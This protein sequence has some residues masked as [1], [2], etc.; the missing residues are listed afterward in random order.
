M[1]ARIIVV[2]AVAAGLGAIG[3]WALESDAP[4]L[5]VSV[6]TQ[7]AASPPASGPS[8]AAAR[9]A[10]AAGDC[11]DLDADGCIDSG[12]DPARDGLAF[13]NE[14]ATGTLSAAALIAL[15]GAESVCATVSGQGCVLYPAAAQ[16]ARQVNEAMVGGRCEG[17]AVL[18][19][20][21][22]GG[23]ISVEDLDPE[24]GT[25]SA[26]TRA[27]PA[28][29]GAIQTWWATQLL[30]PAQAAA[31]SSRLYSPSSIVQ[32]L[33]GGLLSDAGYTLGLEVPGGA[34]SVLPFAVHRS[35]EDFAV[36]VYDSDYPGTVQ[37]VLVDPR[38]ERWTYAPG[39][40]AVS[41]DAWEGGM[42][43]IE[44]TPMSI[45]ALPARAP[46]DASMLAL[47][48]VAGATAG[49]VTLLVTSPDPSA[50]VGVALTVKGRTIDASELG[51]RLPRGVSVRRIL[52]TGLAGSGVT[53]TINRG[54]VPSFAAA[55][56]AWDAAGSQTPTTI[57][58][59]AP[60]RPRITV[61]SP[62][63]LTADALP[64]ANLVR[65]RS[66]ARDG[67]PLVVVES[68]RTFVR[69]PQVNIA[70]GLNSV[71]LTL[72]SGAL[73]LEVTKGKAGSAQLAFRSRGGRV[74]ADYV[75]PFDTPSGR[76]RVANVSISPSGR[77]VDEAEAFARPVPIDESV[78]E[79][80]EAVSSVDA[81][82]AAGSADPAAAS[83][84][85]AAQLAI[86]VSNVGRSGV[87]GT[88][89]RLTSSGG[90][91]TG[92]VRFVVTGEDCAIVRG[93]LVTTAPTT[94]RVTATRAGSG[95]FGASASSPVAFTFRA[96]RQAPLVIS[97]PSRPGAAAN[98][99]RLTAGGGS[100]S[101]ALSFSARGRG[102]SVERNILVA[103]RPGTCVVTASK[104]ASGIYAGA[105]SSSRA[106]TF[107]RADQQ[108]LLISNE[109]RTVVAGTP[110]ALVTRGGSGSGQV[111]FEAD[112]AG[113]Q[114]VG[115]TLTAAAP[116]AC[117]VIAT[118]AASG[119]YR[120]G[121][122]HRVTFTF[123]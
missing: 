28:V 63:M 2:L 81:G 77:V 47:S 27:S 106:L 7:A 4:P 50:R 109:L 35:G 48:P 60:G 49:S 116:T 22:F 57:S 121:R 34:H 102:C 119:I 101:G 15:F 91:G 25:T 66:S 74:L 54:K 114:V 108:E 82:A 53:V 41:G 8:P 80:L 115:S 59:D 10:G 19:Q 51:A 65:S 76:V 24:A 104:S 78:L 5:P 42:G 62:N 107:T 97:N 100:G 103:S 99:I 1:L 118:K 92:A 79:V 14:S 122:S 84:G 89:V 71:N 70:N 86:A 18:A 120:S 26:L 110:V 39:P 67:F 69:G 123:G 3:T 87:A 30:P 112:G 32:E 40:T 44:L 17:M 75:V 85:D 37:E 13:G 43:T 11:A 45:R 55:P 6:E 58:V 111:T 52:G 9:A 83:G 98:P 23:E 20:R 12:F 31:D 93:T 117:G 73:V 56:I 88:P 68:G 38:S 61:R 94:C 72:P 46:F 95:N 33:S 105:R 21:I 29:T 16:W 90:S 113:C 96:A 36:S 64:R